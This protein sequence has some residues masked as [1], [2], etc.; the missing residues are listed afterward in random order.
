MVG[1]VSY[2][3][4]THLQGQAALSNA[5]GGGNKFFGNSAS[6]NSYDMDYKILEFFLE[7][8]SKLMNMPYSAYGFFV[9]NTDAKNN[10]TT[11]K[12]EDSDYNIGATLNKA[13]KQWDWQVAYDYRD[14][15]A[16]AVVGQLNDSDFLGGS[17]GGK[18]HRIAAALQLAKNTQLALTHFF[19]NKYD[20]SQGTSKEGKKYNRL[21]I[22]IK[23]KVK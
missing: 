14:V 11:G 4:F 10:A 20:A 9:S 7:W 18:G 6:G 22:D 19:A 17:T 13:K 8:H 1:G 12:K 15:K 2:Y 21:Q 23:V 16:D 3:D 5:W